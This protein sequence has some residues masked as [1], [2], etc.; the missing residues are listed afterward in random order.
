MHLIIE[1]QNACSETDKT[2][3]RN[4]KTHNDTQRYQQLIDIFIG[5]F[6]PKQ[7]N[8][9]SFPIYKNII[10]IDYK[11]TINKFGRINAI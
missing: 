2:T 10:K 5:H 7:H 8:T 9:H 1:L 4:R 11:T 3:M 6:I